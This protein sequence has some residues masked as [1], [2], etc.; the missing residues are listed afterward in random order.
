MKR[1]IWMLGGTALLSSLFVACPGPGNNGPG[2][3]AGLD[4]NDIE[5]LDPVV[6]VSGTVALYPEALAWLQ[7]NGQ[8]V[9]AIDGLTLR[10]EEPLK[11]ALEDPTG[12]FGSV[13]LQSDGAFRVE[14]VDTAQVNV[15]IAGGIR[16]ERDAGN[17]DIVRTAT[18]LYDVQLHEQKPR[19]DLSGTK[20][21]V[22]PR[23]YLDQLTNAVTAQRIQTVTGNQFGTL[24][25][26]GFILGRVVDQA[27]N[28]V[29]GVKIATSPASWANQIFYPSADLSAVDQAG[30]SGNG[31][32][33]FVHNAGQTETFTFHVEGRPE[34]KRRNGGAATGTGLITTVFPGTTQ[35]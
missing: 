20:A 9:P 10:V 4:A 18:V 21:W 5:E 35:P 30:T 23:A 34:Y 17:S 33:V 3:D 25:E 26:A 28:P 15:G 27:G 8:S 11:V 1:I 2:Q 31:L 16:D 7:A 29:A 6:T 14:N 22:L 13:T 32:F 24:A 19:T 12:I